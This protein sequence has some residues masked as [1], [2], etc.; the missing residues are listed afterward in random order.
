MVKN[1]RWHLFCSRFL[2]VKGGLFCYRSYAVWENFCFCYF[3]K[4]VFCFKIVLKSIFKSLTQIV[5]SSC[6]RIPKN[7]IRF[8][9]L[10]KPFFSYF[11]ST[12]MFVRM[13]SEKNIS[14][15]IFFEVCINQPTEKT[16]KDDLRSTL[17]QYFFRAT[18][19]TNR[20]NS[21]YLRRSGYIDQTLL[22]TN[23]YRNLELR[24]K[25]SWSKV[26][27]RIFRSLTHPKSGW[28][29]V[30]KR[31]FVLFLGTFQWCG[32]ESPRLLFHFTNDPSTPKKKLGTSKFEKI[33]EKS[34]RHKLFFEKSTVP[35][36]KFAHRFSVLK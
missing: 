27:N 2:K 11:H 21:K 5:L 8:I 18:Q 15:L 35:I 31:D 19:E 16:H 30:M 26:Y 14:V 10:F 28:K 3:A 33:T 6:F 12:R 34:T 24:G 29:L 7:N 4:Y 13:P 32:S 9:Y 23:R 1:L 25:L 17:T 20:S 22:I 36:T